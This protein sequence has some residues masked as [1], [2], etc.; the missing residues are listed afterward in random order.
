M[1]TAFFPAIARDGE[2]FLCKVSAKVETPTRAQTRLSIIAPNYLLLESNIHARLR[3][4]ITNLV[5]GDLRYVLHFDV[6]P[7]ENFQPTEEEP[8]GLA[9]GS[10]AMAVLAAIFASRAGFRIS[11]SHL[12]TGPVDPITGL[13][14]VS[15]EM[16]K[17]VNFAR[18]KDFHLLFPMAQITDLEATAQATPILHVPHLLW[19]LNG[20]RN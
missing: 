1:A 13:F 8:L 6:V 19:T 11:P 7:S 3:T 18:S 12:F 2:V 10:F 15:R 4:T 16:T 14:V 9:S 17:K 20:W 5:S